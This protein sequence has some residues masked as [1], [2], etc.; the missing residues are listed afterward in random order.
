MT[1]DTITLRETS[2]TIEPQTPN[3]VS[4]RTIA[5]Y[6]VGNRDAILAIASS[7][8]ALW[9]ALLFVISAGFAREYD[10]EYLLREPWHVF[11]PLGASLLTSFV[12]Y[13]LVD[14]VGR[15]R[16]ALAG[17][18]GPENTSEVLPTNPRVP[19]WRTYR[20]FLT[21]Y[22]MTAPLAWFYAIPFERFLDAGASTRANLMTLAVVSV[23]RVLLITRVV[24][25]LFNASKA[26][27][28][29]VVMLFAD[30]VALASLTVVPIPIIQFMGGVRLTESERL[31]QQTAL[32]I[33]VWGTLSLLVWFLGTV[34]VATVRRDPWKLE[35]PTSELRVTRS[36][37]TFAALS[38]L[39]WIAVLP[40]TQ[41]EQRLRWQV[42]R[43]L[44]AGR[45]D[46][47]MRIMSAQAP[48]DFPPHWDPPPRPAY[49]FGRGNVDVLDVIEAA[50]APGV[51]AW[52]R[53]VYIDKYERFI[54]RE[55]YE[56]YD[57]ESDPL[58]YE[59]HMAVLERLPNRASIVNN[60]RQLLLIH[61]DGDSKVPPELQER[62]RKLL[63]EA[64]EQA[65]GRLSA[66]ARGLR[67]GG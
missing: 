18:A 62:I 55:Y 61:L 17:K 8:N 36:A 5:G 64:R 7:P 24:S 41:A 26:A 9:L 11:I 44:R 2:S 66:S 58:K 16:A 22:W 4:I 39:V 49:Y 20:R 23:W 12:L 57:Y 35:T 63:D 6:L 34:A 60:Q 33:G 13:L 56:V 65:P 10:G 25:V 30:A 53:D 1:T 48:E 50:L 45:I 29:F 19:F 59:R 51:A 43:G 31:I 42:E 27:A 54:N 47:V 14:G 28:F 3:G 46:D 52:V 21:L 32:M 40:A 37:W 38:V 67:D 15:A